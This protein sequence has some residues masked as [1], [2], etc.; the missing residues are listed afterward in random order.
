GRSTGCVPAGRRSGLMRL[1]SGT[2]SGGRW[3]IVVDDDPEIRPLPDPP[4]C[5]GILLPDGNYTG[6]A[7]GYGDVPP[8]SPPCDCPTCN[9]SGYEGPVGT[10]L[11]HADFGDPE[12]CGCLCGTIREQ[13]ADI[14]CNECRTVVRTVPVAD[15]QR[16]LDEMELTLD[17]CTRYV[18]I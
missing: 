6:C 14:V 16:T 9:G 10:A 13:Q 4:R 3:S 7:F 1:P 12:C 17:V 2:P 18:R 15:L 5:R 8:F 11:P